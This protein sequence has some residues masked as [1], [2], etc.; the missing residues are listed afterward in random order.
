MPDFGPQTG[1]IVASYGI[2]AVGLILLI[3][4]SLR[5]RAT[6]RRRL[7]TLEAAEAQP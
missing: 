4:A 2:F 1:Y 6:A 7:A 5:A 3:V